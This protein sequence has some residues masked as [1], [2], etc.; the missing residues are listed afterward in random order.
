V[1]E[2]RDVWAAGFFRETADFDP[3]PMLALRTSRGGRDAFLVGFNA[4]AEL[5]SAMTFGGP[6]DD[7]ALGVA[8]DLA[9]VYVTGAFSGTADFDPGPDVRKICSWGA[10]RSA[11]R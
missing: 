5:L 8:P 7:S 3:S 11:G 2:S 9:A 1:G 4:Q 6:G 10:F